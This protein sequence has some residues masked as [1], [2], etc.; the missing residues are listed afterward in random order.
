[1]R[2]AL[3]HRQ[4]LYNQKQLQNYLLKNDTP[5]KHLAY[6]DFQ[7]SMPISLSF[8]DRSAR[9]THGPDFNSHTLYGTN[10]EPVHSPPKTKIPTIVVEDLRLNSS[11]DG[12]RISKTS[13]IHEL[14]KL[15]DNFGDLQNSLYSSSD[16]ANP[17][18][19]LE[20]HD[21]ASDGS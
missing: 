1:M 6:P 3:D 15:F 9:E 13:G 8:L 17:L 11:T 12:K 18:N 2:F 14:S 4:E 16:S 21:K 5:I 20:V 19:Q 10:D 7:S